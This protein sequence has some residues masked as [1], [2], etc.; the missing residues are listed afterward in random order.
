MNQKTMH[1][2]ELNVGGK[3]V[4]RFVKNEDGSFGRFSAE[5]LKWMQSALDDVCTSTPTDEDYMAALG[6]CGK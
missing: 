4:F 3:Y 1:F 6:P 2:I 5:D